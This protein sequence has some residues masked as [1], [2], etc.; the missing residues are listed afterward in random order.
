MAS[1]REEIVGSSGFAHKLRRECGLDSPEQLAKAALERV[2]KR[3]RRGVNCKN[4]NNFLCALLDEE[5]Q[6]YLEREKEAFDK[7]IEMARQSPEY[8]T[9]HQAVNECIQ[10]IQNASKKPEERLSFIG[11][12]LSDI[13]KLVSES[14]AQSRRTRA[15]SSAQYHIAYVLDQI[16]F[17]GQYEMQQVLDGTVDF[18][19]PG[20]DMWDKDRRKC[21]IVSVKRSLRER[22]KQVYE[23]L[24]ITRGLTVYLIVTEAE[25]E[26]RRDITV[27]KVNNLNNQNVYLVVRDSVKK[28]NFGKSQNVLGFTKF[29]CEE[30]KRLSKSWHDTP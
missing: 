29:F 6:I 3:Y 8:P 4:L 19:F 7:I 22:Y 13:Y 25:E 14:F 27:E 5:Y 18:L 15:G 28:K 1:L 17:A 10:A 21:T 2:L 12:K 26:A 24:G 23:E 9:L 30:L 20:R 16:G 11:L